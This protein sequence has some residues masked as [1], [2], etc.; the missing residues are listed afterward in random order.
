MHLK[1]IA[2]AGMP[3]AGKDITTRRSTGMP[4][5]AILRSCGNGPRWD[6]VKEWSEVLTSPTQAE[7]NENPQHAPPELPNKSHYVLVRNDAS[8]DTMQTF[9]NSGPWVHRD[10]S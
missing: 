2:S 9:T 3:R 5:A 4:G 6:D 8:T 7:I 10:P 1:L